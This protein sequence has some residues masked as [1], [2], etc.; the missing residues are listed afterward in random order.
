[1]STHQGLNGDTAGKILSRENEFID[2]SRHKADKLFRSHTPGKRA[3]SW[4]IRC[5][6]SHSF[7]RRQ[8]NH[9]VCTACN[10]LPSADGSSSSRL[11][12]LAG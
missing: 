12:G 3:D 2:E 8:R 6:I 5:G 4:H 7:A 9:T 1:M 10:R 11:L